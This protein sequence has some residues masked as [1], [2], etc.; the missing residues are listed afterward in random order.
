MSDNLKGVGVA[1]VTPF[2]EKGTIDYIALGNLLQYTAKGGVDYFVVNGTTGESVT[3]TAQEKAEVLKF[4]RENNPKN[5]PIVYGL[6]GNNTQ[7]IL[8]E[9]PKI[10]LSG[11]DALLSVS[12][13]YCLPTQQ[14]IIMHYQALADA[15]PIPIILYNV[16]GRTGSNLSAE[17]TLKLAEHP[18]I[19][20]TKDASKDM[21]QCME[22]ARSKPEDFLLISGDDLLTVPLI[23]IGGEGVISVLANGLPEVFCKMV[24]KAMNGDYKEAQKAIHQVLD[25]NGLLY[26][27][28]NPVGIKQV[29]KELDICEPYVRLPLVQASSE[30]IANLKISLAQFMEK[31]G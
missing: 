12:P 18:N 13:A 3:T 26:N 22:I 7:A 11:V 8:D 20:G 10:E 28:G 1:L 16:P 6:G 23:S 27:E 25:L 9:L 2:T 21:V 5:L 19:I 30:L 14:G 31:A 15:S 29:L 17:T 24:H 4:I